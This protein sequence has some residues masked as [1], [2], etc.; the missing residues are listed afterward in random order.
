MEERNKEITEIVKVIRPNECP[1]FPNGDLDCAKCPMADI[2][3][4]HRCYYYFEAEKVYDNYIVKKYKGV[5]KNE[6]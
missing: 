5:Q 6:E 2:S 3:E 1:H 4:K